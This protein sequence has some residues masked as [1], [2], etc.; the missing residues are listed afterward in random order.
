VCK[1]FAGFYTTNESGWTLV[2]YTKYKK[3]NFYRTDTPQFLEKR[4]LI[5]ERTKNMASMHHVFY[6]TGT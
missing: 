2:S 5:M 4:H 6:R 3:G 1:S